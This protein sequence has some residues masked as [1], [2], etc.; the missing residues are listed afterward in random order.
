MVEPVGGTVAVCPKGGKCFTLRAGRAI[1]MGSTVDTKKGA[2]ELTSVTAPG[3][4]PQT[5]RFSDG[6][7][8]ISQRGAITELTLTE[9]LAPC[10]EEGASGGEEAQVPQAVGQGQ[11]QVPDGRQLQRGDGPRHPA[12]SSQDT[13]AGTLTRVT[14]GV[15]SVRDKVKDKTVIVRARKSYTAKP[16]R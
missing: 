6:I 16:R 9:P 10:G 5:A 7:F 4:P 15:V 2:V 12:G 1:P 8:R 11:G 3:A 13:C 14:E